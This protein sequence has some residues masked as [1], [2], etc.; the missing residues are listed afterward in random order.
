MTEY[1][2]IDDFQAGES[3]RRV[4]VLDRP[5]E[6]SG[7]EKLTIDGHEIDLNNIRTQSE[8]VFDSV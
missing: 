6:F 7:A 3:D 4:L 8:A 2:I 5:Y 1:R